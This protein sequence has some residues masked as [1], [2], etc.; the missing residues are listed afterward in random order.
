MYLLA[1]VVREQ[2]TNS[3]QLRYCVTL[4]YCGHLLMLKLCASTLPAKYVCCLLRPDS[5]CGR[6]TCLWHLC[7]DLL[8]MQ[9]NWLLQELQLL[10]EKTEMYN[11]LPSR[12]I[13]CSN[14][15]PAPQDTGIPGET[16]KSPVLEASPQVSPQVNQ[17]TNRSSTDDGHSPINTQRSQWKLPDHLPIS[18]PTFNWGLQ[19]SAMLI[20]QINEAY[21]EVVH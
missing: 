17:T 4:R 8:Q 12:L 9:S 13:N 11:C 16:N 19:D 14:I 5:K 2:S 10:K 3:T 6:N 15:D 20:V 1:A 18:E 21:I 7:H